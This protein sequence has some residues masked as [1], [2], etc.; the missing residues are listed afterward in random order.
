M[1]NLWRRFA[2]V[3]L[4]LGLLLAGGCEEKEAGPAEYN[5][6]AEFRLGITEQPDSLNPFTARGRMAEEFF[7]LVYDPLWRLNAAGEPVNCLVE[8]WSM[9]SDQL[10]WTLRLR[11]DVTFSDGT[12]LTSEDVRYTYEALMQGDTAYTHCFDGIT[13]VRCP[14]S[15]TVVVTTSYV[16]GDMQYLAVPILPKHIWGAVSGSLA[17]FDNEQMIGSGPFV[18]QLEDTGP[19]EISWIFRARSNYFGG[20]PKIG[21]LRFIYY[22]TATGVGRAISA[23]EPEIDAAIGLTDVQITTLQ[24]VPGVR[25]MQAYLPGSQIWAIAFNTREGV[26]AEAGMRQMVEYCTDRARIVSM[27]AGDAATAG[28]SWASPG[29]DYHYEVNGLRGYN[30]DAAAAILN[31]MGYADLNM[32]GHV[33]H[34]GTRNDL[35]LTLVT[36]SQDDWSSSAATI[37]TEALTA[38]GVQVSRPVTDGPV[39]DKCGPQDD[40]DMCM[41]SWR[42]SSNAVM[43]AQQFYGS[44]ASL[45]GWSSDNYMSTFGRLQVALDRNDV[46]DLAGQLQQIVYDECPYLILGYHS[47]IQAIREDG[48]TG[49]DDTLSAAGALFC[50]GSADAY[51]TLTPAGAG[52]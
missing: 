23:P 35:V 6:G 14:D 11:R 19:Q 47:D 13:S 45:T 8:D 42:G 43:A 52:D 46:R 48:W 33:E 22:A 4:A 30:P 25:Q 36:S 17:D 41:V 7:L 16:K 24:G 9:S 34:I 38:Q 32:D 29:V 40:W 28:S 12:P 37:L 21:Q 20:S 50:N 2:A 51:M 44:D 31:S 49:Y 3:I 10:T 26:F 27:S 18:R 1:K 15:S 39:Q 5:E